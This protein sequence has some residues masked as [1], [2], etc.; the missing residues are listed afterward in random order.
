M[1]KKPQKF[2]RR[3]A[4]NELSEPMLEKLITGH[5][6]F[7]EFTTDE[8]KKAWLEHKDTIMGLI[9]KRIPYGTRPFFWW[10]N[11]AP[12]PRKLLK[13]DPSLALPGEMYFGGINGF[14]VFDPDKII[15]NPYPPKVVI[16]NLKILNK[17]VPFIKI[18]HKDTTIYKSI[19]EI[20][21]LKLS[22]KEDVIS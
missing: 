12:E 19:S 22:Y 14:N 4:E 16:N 15:D 9:G 13:G 8:L 3:I 10:T 6:F 7:V 17:S 1:P 18:K 20:D 5:S 2:K 11:E 21:N